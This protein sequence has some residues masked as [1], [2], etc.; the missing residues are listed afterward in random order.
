MADEPSG[1]HDISFERL[2][3]WV[4]L[5]RG[6]GAAIDAKKLILAALGLILFSLG[7]GGLDRLFP[8]PGAI[9]E[10]ITPLLAGPPAPAPY[11]WADLSSTAWRLTEPVRYLVGPFLEVFA[12]D[13]HWKGFL[14]GLL[15]AFWG[16]LVW[17]IFGGAIARITV[18]Q[19]ARTEGVG[20]GEALR[21]AI[22]KWLPLV[23][24]PLSPLLGVAFFTALCAAFGLL[25]WLPGPWG[26]TLAGIFA[27]FPLLAGLVMSLVLIS[28]AIGWPLMH[29]TIAA[30]G[31]DGFD[32][33]SRSFAYVNQRPLRYAACVALAWALGVLGL[34]VV[35]LFAR[36]T[37]HMAHW[38]LSFGA[39]D[40]LLAALF[41]AGTGP[42]DSAPRAVHAFWLSV[43]GL[44]VHG[45]IYS[46]FW[47]SA[48]II[49]LVLRQDVDGTPWHV[50][51]APE[52]RPFA[53]APGPIGDAPG[54]AGIG[55]L[56]GPS[57]PAVAVAP[58]APAP[59]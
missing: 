46:Y 13:N 35:D 25:Y 19:V 33:L 15:A 7:R 22:Q 59:S 58:D 2:F 45:W 57:T 37:I 54:A 1:L 50:I 11:S 10:T 56:P 18:V 12:L 39:P 4:R 32:A 43:V 31:E 34:I 42:V 9:P 3:P 52:R 44:V 55:D 47:T 6:V 41:R 29:A 27:I 14:H 51:A 20:M 5:F 49:Y 17:G 38:A 28:L 24:T 48:T 16:V 36:T 23:G 40:D 8:R 30:E 53:F 21:F 26:P